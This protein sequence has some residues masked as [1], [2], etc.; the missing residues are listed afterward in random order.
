[1]PKFDGVTCLSVSS[2]YPHKNLGIIEGVVRYLHRTHPLFKL[3]FVLTC[4]EEQ[5]PFPEDIKQSIVYVGKVD[6][7]ECPFL[8]E[9]S[10]IM[11][12]PTL[13]ECF[14]ATYPEAMRMDVPIVT[15]DLEFA[16]GL[17]GDSACYFSAVDAAA[18]AEAIYKVATDREYAGQLVE[19]GREQLLKFDNYEQRAGTLIS[20]LEEM[21]NK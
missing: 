12:M 17:C 11:F 6:V 7:S 8:Y 19:N 18:A 10:D 3:R 9:Q 21:T 1:M 4:S 20:L 15:T 13:L 5:C 14:S 16:H 2:P